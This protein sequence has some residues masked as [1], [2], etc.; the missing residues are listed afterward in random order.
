MADLRLLHC[1]G[2][3]LALRLYPEGDELTTVML[4][5]VN[6]WIME[7]FCPMVVAAHC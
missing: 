3:S 4:S 5:D 2:F 6:R 7:S 1:A